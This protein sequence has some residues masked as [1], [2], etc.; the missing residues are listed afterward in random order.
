[1]DSGFFIAAMPR[2]PRKSKKTYSEKLKDRRWQDRVFEIKTRDGNKCQINESHRTDQLHV[3]HKY[4]RNGADPWDYPDE[5]LITLCASCHWEHEQLMDEIKYLA[6]MGGKA[7][8][9][10]VIRFMKATAENYGYGWVKEKPAPPPEPE[11]R[12]MTIDEKEMALGTF[13]KLRVE[14]GREKPGDKELIERADFL[15]ANMT[16]IQKLREAMGR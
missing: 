7:F 2:K 5:A 16:P 6:G 10:E 4:Y 1:M 9:E 3:H 14:S 11:R 15:R 8:M 13:A 12:E